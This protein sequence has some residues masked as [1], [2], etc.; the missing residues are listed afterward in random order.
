MCMRV[1]AE[2]VAGAH[3]A[4]ICSNKTQELVLFME[5][6]LHATKKLVFVFGFIFLLLVVFSNCFGF[7]FWYF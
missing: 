4:C 6:V 7:F 3:C 1:R 5:Q 2:G